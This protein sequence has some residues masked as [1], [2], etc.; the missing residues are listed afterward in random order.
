M[1]PSKQP[2]ARKRRAPGAPADTVQTP[3]DSSSAL[4]GV[5]LSHYQRD[6]LQAVLA[7][8]EHYLVNAK[9]GSGKTFTLIQAAKT[10]PPKTNALFMAFNVAIAEELAHKLAGASM[11]A[12]NVHKIG[13]A[14]LTRLLSG[15][16]Q[17]AP[18]KYTDIALA[19]V[20]RYMLPHAGYDQWR[21]A[22]AIK[23]IAHHARMSLV[24]PRDHD[25]LVALMDHHAIDLDPRLLDAL[26]DTV[27]M[28]ITAGERVA[29]ERHVMDYDDMI[30]LVHRWHLQPAQATWVFA[31][32]VQD[33]SAAQ[34]E[35]IVRL[36]APDG[37]LLAVGDPNQAI[38]G[39]A[40]ADSDAFYTIRDR[41]QATV[42][43]LSICYRCARS[44]IALAQTI[45]LEIEAAP[46]A[47]EG[48]VGTIPESELAQ[49]L[50]PNDMVLCRLTAPLVSLCVQLIQQ[51]IPAKVKGRD[52]GKQLS[53]LI[54]AVRHMPQFQYAGF[55]RFLTAYQD[56]QE[57]K[58]AQRRNAESL[59]AGLRDRCE[60]V[61]VCYESYG[62][63][64]AEELAR[65]IESL[66]SDERQVINLMTIHRSKGLEAERVFILKP[67]SLPLTWQHQQPWQAQQEMN[68]KYVAI[69]RARREL[70][71]VEA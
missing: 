4:P 3:L 47:P 69:T 25:A 48:I 10:L 46:G 68:L 1:I 56:E 58:L 41:M 55:G 64:S 49:R 40:G 52:M 66:F 15:N 22:T 65:Q 31:D 60:T 33:I 14:A 12:K 8:D 6:V 16:I 24:N 71:F 36:I 28:A 29:R 13:F 54:D 50:R 44:V 17:V 26:S 42:L 11:V 57:A 34:L 2:R 7:G 37:R 30:S 19:A 35:L 20:E 21:A 70:Y 43:P 38:Y 61:R 27:T 53:D 32:E 62:C 45:V 51:R 18:D 39:F 5:T 9:E 23:E 67:D 59:I 63:R